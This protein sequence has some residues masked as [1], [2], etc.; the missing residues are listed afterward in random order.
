MEEVEHIGS[1]YLDKI[2]VL[3]PKYKIKISYAGFPVYKT[4]EEIYKEK[5]DWISPKTLISLIE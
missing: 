3:S 1:E 5:D 2:E 4:V